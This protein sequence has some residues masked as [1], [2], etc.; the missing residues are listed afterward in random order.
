MAPVAWDE[1]AVQRIPTGSG[2]R[3]RDPYEGRTGQGKSAVESL[4]EM[5][6]LVVT[7][8][9]QQSLSY[10][11][12]C[13]ITGYPLSIVKN[14][15]Y[16][17]R[18]MLCENLEHIM[19]MGSRGGGFVGCEKAW[20]LMMSRMD[21]EIQGRDSMILENHLRIC[22]E[23]RRQEASLH[24]V[25]QELER[26]RP[27][28]PESTERK[29]MERICDARRKETA[30]ILPYV[31]LPAALLAGLLAYLLYKLYMSGPVILIDKAARTLTV[32][33]KVCQSV[34]AVSNVLFNTQYLGGILMMVGFSLFAGII[35]L[36]SRQLRKKGI[37]QAYWR[38][39]K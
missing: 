39:I 28:A 23:C 21:G 1:E 9:H 13:Q 17:A 38:T 14:R 22:P 11:E 7:L 31:V 4:P 15:L 29:V 32:F 2:F 34:A 12:I 5:Y 35:V 24:T 37:S 8:F 30:A 10:D 25:V 16:R 20:E 33:Y 27:V 36:I 6:R 18:K 26:S 3:G 19:E